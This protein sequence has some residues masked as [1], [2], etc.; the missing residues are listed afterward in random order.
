[1]KT[2]Y[3][4]QIQTHTKYGIL[5][6]VIYT[7]KA[8]NS[9]TLS[10]VKKGNTSSI[11]NMAIVKRKFSFARSLLQWASSN[12]CSQIFSYKNSRPFYEAF[13]P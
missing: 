12:S 6:A 11:S 3:R 8:Q 1:M 5:T 7:A 10:D 9:Q 13:Q 4:Y 2:V